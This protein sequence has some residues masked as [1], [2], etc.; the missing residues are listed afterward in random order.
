MFS[1]FYHFFFLL[2][3]CKPVNDLAKMWPLCTSLSNWSWSLSFFFTSCFIFN[4][5]IC[6]CR[7][8]IASESHIQHEHCNTVVQ[9]NVAN[10][11]RTLLMAMKILKLLT[12]T[13]LFSP[14][15]MRATADERFKMRKTVAAATAFLW[16]QE[17][18]MSWKRPSQNLA[19][20]QY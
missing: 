15:Q 12:I 11:V 3:F 17:S 19:A 10:N 7:L 6:N 1:F 18:Q 16:E 13:K 14:S 20:I 2:F 9:Q 5:F 8:L 4:P